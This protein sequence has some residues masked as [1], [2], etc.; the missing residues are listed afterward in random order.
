MLTIT[1]NAAI[2][3]TGIN[4]GALRDIDDPHYQAPTVNDVHALK[5]ASG[6]TRGK[7]AARL[8]ARPKDVDKWLAASESSH[9]PIPWTAWIVWL[10]TAG[11]ITVTTNKE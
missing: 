3:A 4:P 10:Q 1:P 7:I 9:R 5:A 11:F 6:W 2:T 8:S